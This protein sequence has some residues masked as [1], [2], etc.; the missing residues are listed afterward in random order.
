VV[1][2]RFEINVKTSTVLGIVGAGGIGSSLRNSLVTFDFTRASAIAISLIATIFILEIISMSSR[3]ALI[4]SA[5]LPF[6]GTNKRNLFS[7]IQK[8]PKAAVLIS[9]S[10]IA[11]IGLVGSV[12]YVIS[13]FTPRNRDLDIFMQVIT[14]LAMPDFFGSGSNLFLLM[15][16]TVEIGFLATV[17]GAVL[18]M[19]L[20][21]Y[22]SWNVAPTKNIF[23][24][25]R[26]LM[27]LIRGMP[28]VMFALIF[29]T[30]IGLG[31][32]AGVL[33]MSIASLGLC[34]KLT[35][36]SIEM[37]LPGPRVAVISLGASRPQEFFA[38][39]FPQ[40]KS[41]IL[42]NVLFALDINVRQATLLGLV[43]AGGIGYA[44]VEAVNLFQFDTVSA[45]VLL[46]I[47]TVLMLEL[48]AKQLKASLD[49]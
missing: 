4:G 24:I 47:S 31:P 48:V 6:N 7:R 37:A 32:V 44:L 36:D 34:S 27:A 40:V 25:S 11:F 18:G 43:G 2:Y 16:E 42:S 46:I 39:V 38:A 19:P 23:L 22:A 5:Q 20:A 14:Q 8:I 26:T 13:G 1:I 9:V 33:A 49:T 45:I 10:I 30:G 35:A 17:I 28:S 3:Y 15:F 21:I 12:H 41:Q 29:V